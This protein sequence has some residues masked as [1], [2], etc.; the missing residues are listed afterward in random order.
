MAVFFTRRGAPPTFI[1][2]VAITQSNVNSYFTVTNGSYYFAGNGSK[3]A[4]NNC[5]VN[6][7][8]A[9]T[10]LTALYDTDVTLDYA[11]VTEASYDKFTLSAAGIALL[12]AVSGTA[13]GSKS[14]HLTA[15][16][17]IELK[18]AKDSS[19]HASGEKCEVSNIK[20]TGEFR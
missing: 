13:S 2:T 12:N 6:S 8:T 9:T 14:F 20:I 10:T 1:E 19:T 5:G 15:G 11:Y 16:Q 7:S 18:Y 4:A 17:K 3:F